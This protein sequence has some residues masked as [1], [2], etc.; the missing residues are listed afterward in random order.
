VLAQPLVS[1]HATKPELIQ[2]PWS[3]L[4]ISFSEYPKTLFELDLN[5]TLLFT[6]VF[7]AQLHHR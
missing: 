2:F 3:S 1:L 7:I 5:Y 4:V 6:V